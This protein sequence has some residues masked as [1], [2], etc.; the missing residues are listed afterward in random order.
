[1]FG[2]HMGR[3]S[4]NMDDFDQ[5]KKQALKSCDKIEE[6]DLFVSIYSKSY[7]EDPT[8]ALQLGLA[9]LMDKPMGFLVMPGVEIAPKLLKMADAIEYCANEEK[10]IEAATGRLLKKLQE[11][12]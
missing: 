2:F 10:S 1:M 8:C 4:K 7:R 3:Y 5:F 6:S 12:F 11:K 9:I